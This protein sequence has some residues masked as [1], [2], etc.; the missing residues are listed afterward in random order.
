MPLTRRRR[1]LW[2]LVFWAG[3]ALVAWLDSDG[4][5]LALRPHL[6]LH[7]A[8]VF[9]AIWAGIEILAGWIA[10]AAEVTATYVWIALQ[11]LAGAVATFLKSTGAMFAKVWDGL[12]I[13]WSDVLRPALIWLN[14]KLQR[15]YAWLKDTFKPVFDF[16]KNVKDRLNAFYKT[17][18]QPVVDTIEFIRQINRVLLAFH[19]TLLQ[20]LDTTLQELEQ[21]IEAPFL[22]INQQ[23]TLLTNW[24]NRI[25][26]ADGLFQRL[27]L[28]TS[29]SRYAPAWMNG[30]WNAQAKIAPGSV[31]EHERTRDFPIDASWSYGDELAKFY[32]AEGSVYT[33]QVDALVPLFRQAAGVDPFTGDYG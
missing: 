5:W 6:A 12:K 11:W 26:T 23:L 29:M 27:T 25:V 33:G 16:L 22:W 28:I 32:R 20:Q 13:M 17:F 19:I 10:T 8:D 9:S 15:V 18:V 21:R 2:S 4:C 3:V 7:R 30:F 1:A 31:D 24:V 14:D